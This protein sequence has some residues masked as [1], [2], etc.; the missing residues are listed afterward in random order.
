MWVIKSSG[1]RWEE[2]VAR[3]VEKRNTYRILVGKPEVQRPLARHQRI[4]DDNIKMVIK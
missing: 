3:M 1:M 4:W 2:R